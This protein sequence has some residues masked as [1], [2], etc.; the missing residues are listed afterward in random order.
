M[1][2]KHELPHLYTISPIVYTPLPHNYSPTYL[3]IHS[4]LPLLIPDTVSFLPS[5]DR[6]SIGPF[7]R[8]SPPAPCTSPDPRYTHSCSLAPRMSCFTHFASPTRYHVTRRSLRLLTSGTLPTCSISL[9]TRETTLLGRAGGWTG[10]A[11][12]RPGAEPEYIREG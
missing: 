5:P 9:A 8:R 11:T 3:L 10:R 6:S 12:S 4:G 1:I 2:S 7:T